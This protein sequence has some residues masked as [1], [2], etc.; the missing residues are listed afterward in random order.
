MQNT[1]VNHLGGFGEAMKANASD[2]YEYFPTNYFEY[3]QASIVRIDMLE[4]E[5]TSSAQD[6]YKIKFEGNH[7]A[8]NRNYQVIA[9]KN[10]E[11]YGSLIELNC[12]I[13]YFKLEFSYNLV[14]YNQFIGQE[15]ALFYINGGLIDIIKNNFSFNIKCIEIGLKR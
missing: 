2:I 13:E 6:A 10:L 12:Q 3:S 9:L 1:F 7:F 8:H 15:S 4:T 5:T 11:Y 14:Q